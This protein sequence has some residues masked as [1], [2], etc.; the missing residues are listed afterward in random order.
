VRRKAEKGGVC[1]CARERLK[2]TGVE[3]ERG[4][5]RG[6]ER[7]GVTVSGRGEI[8]R[9][10]EREREESESERVR[11]ME[12]KRGEGREGESERETWREKLSEK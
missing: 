9:A 11:K 10:K 6:R 3:S 5:E 1:V 12:K 4:R 8:G 7:G 2:E